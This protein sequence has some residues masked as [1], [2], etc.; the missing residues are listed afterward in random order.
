MTIVDQPLLEAA[1]LFDNH[2]PDIRSSLSRQAQAAA[3]GFAPLNDRANAR[4]NARRHVMFRFIGRDIICDF[5]S[6]GEEFQDSLVEQV[7]LLAHENEFVL[8]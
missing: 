6:R 8:H 7:D 1:G 3:G 2:L 5:E 4:R